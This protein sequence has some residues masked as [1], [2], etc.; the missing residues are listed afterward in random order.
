MPRAFLFVVLGLAAILFVVIP[1]KAMRIVKENAQTGHAVDARFLAYYREHGGLEIFGY[2][3]SEAFVEQG[4]GKIIQ[5][6]QNARLEMSADRD[7][8][9]QVKASALGMMLGGWEAPIADPGKV[10]GCRFYQETGHQI[11][12]LFL[13][14]Y[15]RHGGAEVF[16]LPIAEVRIEDEQIVQYFQ[17]FRLDWLSSEGEVGEIRPGPLGQLHMQQ[18]YPELLHSVAGSDQVEA[19]I[20]TTSVENASTSSTGE[21]TVFLR[22]R[23]QNGRPLKGAT[24]TLVAHFPEGDRTIVMPFSDEN[25]RSRASFSF[26][27]QPAGITVNIDLTVFYGALRKETRESFMVSFPEN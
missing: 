25:G 8:Q 5:Y 16:G 4:T 23:D 11:C 14:Y 19:L 20:L 27:N 21:Q 26:E 1:I 24:A 10:A 12:H 18:A 9:Q 22:V 13:E 7:G 6:Y 3:I 2:P 17:W 15:D